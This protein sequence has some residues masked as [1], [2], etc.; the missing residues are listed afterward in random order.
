MPKNKRE[1][2]AISL[3][4]TKI[5]EALSKLSIG[6]VLTLAL[7][8]K[9]VD[10]KS[11]E[12]IYNFLNEILK[13]TKDYSVKEINALTDLFKGLSK[14][15]LT[16][17]IAI[18]VMVLIVSLAKMED[19]LLA[20]GIIT[21]VTVGLVGLTKWIGSKDTQKEMEAGI[22]GL[23]TLTKSALLIV[24]AI[25][26]MTLIVSLF[27]IEDVLLGLAIVAITITGLVIAS[28]YLS[29]KDTEET[30]NNGVKNL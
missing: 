7:F 29:S 10:K 12:N 25:G 24:G 22:K 26:L 3:G 21:L 18:G 30:I 16:L 4:L 20:L 9:L 1:A 28:K 5:I 14:A 19:I 23:E 6:T 15:V 8:G 27:K 13:I 17:S 2:E 11:G